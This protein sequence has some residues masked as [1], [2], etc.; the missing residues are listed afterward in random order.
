MYEWV[1]VVVIGG[2]GGALA[3]AFALWL[4]YERSPLVDD[5][6]LRS[7]GYW[8][9]SILINGA[10]GAVVGFFLWATYTGSSM[11]SMDAPP[12]VLAATLAVGVGGVSAVQ[13]FLYLED[14]LRQTVDENVASVNNLI[15]ASQANDD[16]VDH[17]SD[18]A[19]TVNG[20]DAQ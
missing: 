2:G 8:A 18:P 7:F 15:E 14:G 4:R 20:G 11:S 13:R 3:A 17:A 1:S 5:K 9:F 16:P 19:H 6:R 12:G 10:A